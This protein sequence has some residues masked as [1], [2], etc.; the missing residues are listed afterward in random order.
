[1]PDSHPHDLAEIA[2]MDPRPDI[3]LIAADLDGTLVD[4]EKRIHDEFWP[5][6]DLLHSRGI[7][8]C[9]ASGRQYYNLLALFEDVAA[10]VVFIAENGTYVVADGRE[11]SS[12]CLPLDVARRV[13]ERVRE[14]PDCGAVLCGKRSA[15]VERKD[16][17]FLQHVRPYYTREQAV[18]DLLTVEDEVLKVAVY[19]FVSSERNVGP[20]LAEFRATHQVAISGPQWVD[21]M[22]PTANKGHALRQVQEKLGVTPDQ[23]MAFGDFLNDL[24]MMDAA[25]YSF[26][27][28]NAHPLLKARASWVAPTNNANGV[29]R[30]IR[31]MLGME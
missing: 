15:Y 23:T 11:V 31:T 7:T 20:G 29:V 24:E 2:R 12:D 27:M 22:S 8:F 26:A 18:S 13:I 4:D 14:I 5:L 1:M 10:D 25:T 17:T 19:D 21:V 16:E 30:T 28:A 3:R 9:P 6:V